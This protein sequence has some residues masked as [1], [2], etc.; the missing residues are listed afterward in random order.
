MTSI[1]RRK[2]RGSRA[3]ATTSQTGY[4]INKEK[5]QPWIMWEQWTSTD[6]T[7]RGS[8]DAYRLGVSYFMVGHN[9]N[10]KIGYEKVDAATPIGS[11]NEESVSTFVIGFYTTY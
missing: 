3:T 2:R 9:A 10:L 11:S 4:L 8:F 5:W 1:S 6:P 7:E